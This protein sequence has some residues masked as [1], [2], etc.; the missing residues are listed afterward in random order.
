MQKGTLWVPER[1]A[2]SLVDQGLGL[3]VV[4]MLQRTD[5]VPKSAW[6][7]PQDRPS[8]QTHYDSMVVRNPLEEPASVLL[9]DDIVTRGS[10]LLAGASRIHHLYPECEIRAFAAMRTMTNESDFVKE[11]EPVRGEITYRRMVGDTIRMP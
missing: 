2:S 8:P 6:C 1:I 3:R 10:T 7:A 5:A 11:F 4:P 9:V